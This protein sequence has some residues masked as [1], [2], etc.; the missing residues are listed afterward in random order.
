[1]LMATT[2]S[3]TD[4]CPS[5]DGTGFVI[6]PSCNG[7]RVTRCLFCRGSG[8]TA[9]GTVCNHCAGDG[10]QRCA[11]CQGVGDIRCETCAGVATGRR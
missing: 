7:A 1:M 4:T 3:T 9:D 5:C 6:C 8:R 10:E 11:T 2:A